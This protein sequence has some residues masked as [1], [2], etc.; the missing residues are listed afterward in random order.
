MALTMRNSLLLSVAAGLALAAGFPACSDSP[1]SP[2]SAGWRCD[3]TL[4][5]V[6]STFGSLQSPSGTGSGTGD[7]IYQRGSAIGCVRSSLRTTQSR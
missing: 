7:G 6:P 4:T 3:V 2:S 5:L 1:T